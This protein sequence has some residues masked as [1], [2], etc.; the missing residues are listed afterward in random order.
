M[1]TILGLDLGK[2]KSLAC[3][4]DTDTTAARFTTIHTDP[5]DLRK[6]LEA[7]RPGLVVFETC[8]VAGRVA[9]TCAEL[10]LAY[11]VANP[12]HEAWSW[13]KVK[14]KT[15]RDDALKLAKMAAMGELPTVAMPS[16][17]TR[18]YRGLV[19]YRDRLVGRRT[20]IRNHIRALCQGQ[21]FLLPAG[22]R[23]WTKEGLE[24]IA[25]MARPLHE[26][27]PRE[28]WRGELGL[29]LA[30]L[31]QITSGLKVVEAKLEEIAG[32]DRRV[33]RQLEFSVDDHYFSRTHRPFVTRSRL[34]TGG[35]SWPAPRGSSARS[36]P[37]S[38]NG[39]PAGRSPPP[40]SS[41]P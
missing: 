35:P 15:D 27:G 30:D 40:S 41:R 2:F 33:W 20:A 29:E 12:M 26:C 8:T 10:G 23:S 22:H 14:R 37:R 17:E 3:L 38:R 31:G 4:Y 19:K 32:Q 1:S 5:A 28:S 25:A 34:E 24:L 6:F 11:L 36:T 16:R 21:G 9:D 39:G 7:E 13:R 18:Q